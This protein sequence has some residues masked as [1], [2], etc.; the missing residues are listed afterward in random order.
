MVLRVITALLLAT[1][2]TC[3]HALVFAINEGVTYRVS[4]EDIELRY[5]TISAD[6][7]RLLNQPV[8]IRPVA[9]YDELRRGLANK[10]FDLAIVHPAHLSIAAIKNSGYRLLAVAKGYQKYTA[11]ILVKPDSMITSITDLRHQVVG[12]PDED[13]ITAWITRATLR[14]ALGD[15]RQVKYQYTRYQDAVPFLVANDLTNAGSTGAGSVVKAWLTQGGRVLAE[16]RP[17]PIKHVIASPKLTLEQ[18][19]QV[20]AYFLTLEITPAGRKKLQAIK[21]EGF[22]PY[23]QTDLMHIGT[24]LGL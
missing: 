10:E 7:T 13:S 23:S 21:Y 3:S 19:E 5:A 12:L 4:A 1:A 18:S 15:S 2:A 22:V 6:L 16:S 8:I 9:H 20:R 24:W 11:K 17:V 14:D